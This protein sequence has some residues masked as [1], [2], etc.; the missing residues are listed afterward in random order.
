MKF[1][2]F[3][4][5]SVISA[6]GA[7]PKPNSSEVRLIHD[8]FR[9]YTKSLNSYAKLVQDATHYVSLDQVVVAKLQPKGWLAKV[10]L[11]HAYRCVPIS[12]SNYCVTGLKWKFTLWCAE[13]ARNFFQRIT[14]SVTCKLHRRGYKSV[15][16]YLDDFIIVT[17]TEKRC[18][19]A[20]QC[21]L[22]VLMRLGFTVNR[23]KVVEPSQKIIFLGVS[24]DSLSRKISI[25]QDKL[26]EIKDELKCWRLR[27]RLQRDN[28]SS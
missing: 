16:V 22:G 10:D 2:Q 24:I 6:L 8:A 13:E 25:P 1:Y 23:N 5:Q 12:P 9:P 14:E 27:K 19:E 11:L 15:F 4:K 28:Y 18:W 21:L 7:I 26:I 17:D 20:Y 3:G